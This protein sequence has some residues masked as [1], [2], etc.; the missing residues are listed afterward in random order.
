MRK[1]V[2]IASTFIVV[3]LLVRFCFEP[4][5]NASELPYADFST[6]L[7][8]GSAPARI[9]HVDLQRGLCD[10]WGHEIVML[11]LRDNAR[12][13]FMYVPTDFYERVIPQLPGMNVKC[14]A[15]DSSL[16]CLQVLLVVATTA[17][18]TA[19]LMLASWLD[20]MRGVDRRSAES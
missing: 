7:K 18:V 9:A 2:I 13:R 3:S 1:S 20:K 12:P 5:R 10:A 17:A 19:Y 6:M 14:V 4:T 8:D 11:T 15:V 16:P